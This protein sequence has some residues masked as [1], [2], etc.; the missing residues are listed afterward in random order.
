[1]ETAPES[2][3]EIAVFANI[4]AIAGA[5]RRVRAGRR[6]GRQLVVL[7]FEA[8]QAGEPALWSVPEPSQRQFVM[9][10]SQ[11]R[12]HARAAGPSF[13]ELFT[14][15]LVTVLREGY[16]LADLRAD[17]VAGLTVAIVA[18]PL[19]MAFAIASGI[20]PG[21]R[22]LYGDRRRLSGLR[23][24][25]A[26]ASRS[27][28]RRAPSSFSSPPSC[29]RHGY[30][31][32][33][34]ATMMAGVILLAIGLL[35]ARHLHQIHPLSG[36]GRLHRGHRRHHLREPDQGSSR[37]RHS[38]RAG[39]ARCPSSRRSGRRIGSFQP[40][41]IAV[42]ALA[43][44]VILG[45]RRFRPHLAGNADR[46]R[47]SAPRRRRLC[48]STSRRS[49]RASAAFRRRCRRRRCPPSIWRKMRALLPDALTIA[50]LGAIES[51]LSA[52]VADG[53]SGRRHRSN[54]ELVA[55]GDRQYRRGRSSAAFRV[56]GT[57]ARTAT[58]VRSGAHGSDRP[59]CCMRRFCSLFM[60]V[61]APLA[62][63]IPLA[64][65]G[66]VLAVVSWNMAEKKEFV[67]LFR[68]S[69]G[70]ALVLL[71]TFLL[72]I[73][74]DLTI[75]IGVGVTLGAFLFLHRMAEASK[76]RRAGSST[77]IRPM[78]TADRPPMMPAAATDREVMVYKISGAIFF[79]A[80]AG[81]RGAGRD[82]PLSARFIFDFTDAPLVDSTAAR[83]LETFVARLRR[84]GTQ[85][86]V[87]GARPSVRRALIN[88][89][90]TNPDVAF[91]ASVDAA[92]ASIA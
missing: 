76:C 40:T 68:A 20:A 2:P 4:R 18:L 33:A 29:E 57:I 45:L 90:I 16:G 87:A 67:A 46:R 70:D 34:L 38:A 44:A 47:A 5:T 59:A 63:F 27:A 86:C 13:A 83:A 77:R 36:D 3:C 52:V 11:A 41:T 50:L 65:L 82:R 9:E 55:Q 7:D 60:L 1:M 43:L 8:A 53:M 14:P 48:I 31:G 6:P 17:A 28:G 92:R 73:F 69:R 49:A 42:S 58:N 66:A 51:L 25:A 85:V 64:S 79:G 89:G 26:A 37:P 78:I 32:L 22:A 24:S 30:D 54:C 62:S 19:S 91:A 10:H 88:A 35:R 80:S 61:A 81:E 23:C 56:T 74:E 71:A 72:T 39:R 21:P 12:P 84:A 75:G 15:K